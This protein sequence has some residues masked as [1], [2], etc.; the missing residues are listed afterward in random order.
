[1]SYKLV[2]SDKLDNDLTTIANAI[3]SKIDDQSTLE[4]PSGFVTAIANITGSAIEN[5]NTTAEMDALL[6]EENVGKTYRY[7][8]ETAEEYVNGDIYVVENTEEAI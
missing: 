6:V 5:I 1:M 3:R 4:F 2:D 8:G 7:V